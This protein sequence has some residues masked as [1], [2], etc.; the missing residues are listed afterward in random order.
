[1]QN[2]CWRRLELLWQSPMTT[3]YDFVPLFLQILLQTNQLLVVD[4][5]AHLHLVEKMLD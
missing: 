4:T 3:Q 1:M 5:Q 2:H